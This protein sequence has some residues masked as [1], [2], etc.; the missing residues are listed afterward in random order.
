[1]TCWISVFSSGIVCNLLETLNFTK[2]LRKKSHGQVSISTF[3]NHNQKNVVITN[4][5]FLLLYGVWLH[6]VETTFLRGT[7]FPIDPTTSS[8]P[9]LDIVPHFGQIRS[10]K[11]TIQSHLCF[12]NNNTLFFLKSDPFFNYLNDI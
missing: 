1:M 3:G 8:I 12:N 2:P 5:W 4:L 7:Y 11:R 10:R 9:Y 6:L